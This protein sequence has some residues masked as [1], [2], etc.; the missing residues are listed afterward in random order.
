MKAIG[1]TEFGG[2]DVL[3][4]VDLP[5]PEPGTSEVRIRV[6][7]VAVN[8]TDATF[9]AG[10]R[11]A[12]PADRT[13]PYIPGLDAAGVVDKLGPGI[14]GRLSVTDRVIALVIPVSPHG[15]TYAEQIVTD[16]RSVVR[17]AEDTT[18]AEAATLLLNAVA[19]RLALDALDLQAGQAVAVT[20][21]AGAVDGYAIQLARA[22]SL[23]GA[24]R[25]GD[26]PAEQVVL[27]VLGEIARNELRHEDALA[28]FGA[29][30]QQGTDQ[31]LAQ[32]TAALRL[33]D[34]FDEAQAV[35]DAAGR[36][37]DERR[38]AVQPSLAEARMWQD[39]MLGRFDEAQADART[40]ARLSD[41]LGTAAYRLE[42]AMVLI[43]TAIIGGDT[44][45][46]REHLARAGR[47]E[48]S[49]DIAGIPGLRLCRSLLAG[50]D[51]DPAEAVRI[52]RPVMS[53]ASSTRS[54]WPRLPEW[55]RVHAGLAI[56]A[57]DRGFAR[58]TV[59]RAATAA[60]RNPGAA[61]L[62]GIALQVRGLVD[63]DAGLLARAV[64]RL[65][66]SPRVMLLASAL[67]D[68]GSLLLARGDRAEAT[69]ALQRAWSV[70]HDHGAV[71]LAASVA[72]TLEAA[73]V[74]AGSPA[75]PR[76]PGKGWQA[77]TAA[78]LAVAELI[79]AG[80][81]NRIAARALGISPH[82]VST[83]VRSVFAKLDV[84]S[85]VQLANA[86]NARGS[87][88]AAGAFHHPNG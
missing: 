57:G 73:A 1:L 61:S 43:L 26:R 52:I 81:T 85:R 59:A 84:R 50:L 13:P 72:R 46:A 6:R 42:T 44:A 14:G 31:Y 8:P 86:W 47:N 80:Q 25:L 30:R 18:D 66:R 9:R 77:L 68:H 29:L 83:H 5:V 21:A 17:A 41:E 33:L 12:Q 54:Y 10:G 11:A 48:R 35:M 27:Q 62:D 37:A 64:D 15:G 20:G 65:E 2:P 32:E 79:S 78:E 67:A 49:G 51:G 87:P 34:R 38:E 60:E 88:P 45:R 16:E 74:S 22:R 23:A 7:A 63:G 39:F 36:A 69:G 4:I 53:R 70:Y 58:E 56:A 24:R 19:A 76:R 71:A 55:M 28:C 40:L 82:T 75:P 3:H